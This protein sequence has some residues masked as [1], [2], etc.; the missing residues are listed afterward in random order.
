M[1]VLPDGL[2]PTVVVVKIG[3]GQEVAGA[4]DTAA[5][6]GHP[7]FIDSHSRAGDATTGLAII[8]GFCQ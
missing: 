5:G 6:G 3:A 4:Q 1:V 8:Y 7:A 2:G